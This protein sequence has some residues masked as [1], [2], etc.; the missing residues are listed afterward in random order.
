MSIVRCW[1]EAKLAA[2]GIHRDS[3]DPLHVSNLLDACGFKP[4]LIISA[5]DTIVV[6]EPRG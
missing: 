4:S 5:N 2:V 1:R 3:A 6:G